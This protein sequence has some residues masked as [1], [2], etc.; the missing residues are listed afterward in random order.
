MRFYS[1]NS[2][3]KIIISIC[4]ILFLF[5]VMPKAFAIPGL[6]IDIV[7]ADYLNDFN[8]DGDTDDPCDEGVVATDSTFTLQALWQTDEQSDSD[9]SNKEFFVSSALLTPDGQ[10]VT[11]L[12]GSPSI[13]IDSTPVNTWILGKPDKMPPH[14]VFDTFYNEFSFHFVSSEYTSDGIY[15]V[16]DGT[17]QASGYIHDLSFN[18]TGLPGGYILVFDVYTYDTNGNKK[19][20]NAPFSH[21]GCYHDPAQSPRLSFFC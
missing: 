5:G 14:G 7:G 4:S 19:I 13:T 16:A 17:G 8:G 18:A 10:K 3:K 20:T 1:L 9:L 15:N 2:M 12:I 6:Q 21:N 11:S